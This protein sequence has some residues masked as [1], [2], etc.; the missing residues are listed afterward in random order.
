M[1]ERT[2]NISHVM[3]KDY[4][5]KHLNSNNKILFSGF[6]EGTSGGENKTMHVKM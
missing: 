3:M 1:S 2:N 6:V 5:H 4:I